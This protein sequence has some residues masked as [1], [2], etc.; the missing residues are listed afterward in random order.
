[1][2]PPCPGRHLR[3][4]VKLIMYRRFKAAFEAY[5]ERELPI[6]KEEHPGLRQNQMR[7]KI[8]NNFKKA[9]ENRTFPSVLNH[10]SPGR[11]FS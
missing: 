1:M 6:L 7:D 5:L 10:L 4:R 3:N 9:P 11:L 2:H 8:F